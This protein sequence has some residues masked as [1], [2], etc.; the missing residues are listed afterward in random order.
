MSGF[1]DSFKKGG[2]GGGSGGGEEE[3]LEYDDSA[4]YYFSM[5]LLTC[6]TVPFTYYTMRMALEG[7]FPVLHSAKNCQARQF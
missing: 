4:F 2:E 1:G 7:E 6:I 5:A 3:M